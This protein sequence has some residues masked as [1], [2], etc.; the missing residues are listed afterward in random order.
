[1]HEKKNYKSGNSGSNKGIV[2][3]ECPMSAEDCESF[4]T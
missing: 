4:L 2:N 1:M 3:H